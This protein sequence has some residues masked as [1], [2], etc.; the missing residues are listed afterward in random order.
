MR[1]TPA[2]FAK[3]SVEYRNFDRQFGDLPLRFYSDLYFPDDRNDENTESIRLGFHHALSSQSDL[4]GTVVTADYD[5]VFTNDPLDFTYDYVDDRN[6]AEL[7]HIIRSNRVNLLYGVSYFRADATS[8]ATFGGPVSVAI[9]ENDEIKE[10]SKA[11]AYLNMDLPD[12]VIWTV[13]TSIESFNGIIDKDLVNPK[14]G[15]TW[16]PLDSTTV[17]AAATH[18]LRSHFINDQ[19]LEPTHVAGFNQFFDDSEGAEAWRFGIAVDHKLNDTLFGGIELSQRDLDVAYEFFFLAGQTEWH[20]KQAR[21]YLSWVP[22]RWFSGTLEYIEEQF[23]R[24]LECTGAELIHDLKIH[25]FPINLN[26][27]LAS[28]LTG[29]LNAT[30][31]DQAGEFE[32]NPLS[33]QPVNG[34]DNFWVVDLSLRYRLPRRY[35]MLSLEIRNLFDEA[36]QFQ[37][38][39]PSSPEYVPERWVLGKLTISF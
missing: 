27:F 7:Q 35:G 12:T 31:V 10:D 22:V 21:L 2:H 14:L 4:I 6:M 11:Y 25:K 15:V 26:V 13:G 28:G 17:R 3:A 20:E 18:V 39:D 33:S 30:F 34:G 37:T 36:F 16:S 23:E 5:Y 9:M 1:R 24:D 38:L 29:T 8:L 19:S 32:L